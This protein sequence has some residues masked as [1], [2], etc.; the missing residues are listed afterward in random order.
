MPRT[1]QARPKRTPAMFR[2]TQVL[3]KTTKK[4]A[5]KPARKK[6]FQARRNPFIENKTRE[7]K[8]FSASLD[9]MR[10]KTATS[11]PL[12]VPTAFP[13]PTDFRYMPVDDAQTIIL[14]S[15]FYSMNR[16]LTENE[17]IGSAIYGKYL[18][19]KIQLLAPE[20]ANM[21]DYPSN[22]YVIHGWVTAP[23][24]ATGLTVP[25]V[26][27]T[28][29]VDVFTH[30]YNYIKEY[31]SVRKDTLEFPEKR[32]QHIQFLGSRKVL[33]DKNANI[34]VQGV[35][36]VA[37][38]R[39]ALAPINISCKWDINRKIHYSQGTSVAANGNPSNYPQAVF[40]YPNNSWLPF[41]VLFNPQFASTPGYDATAPDP[42]SGVSNNDLWR[43][44]HNSKMWYSDS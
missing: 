31:Y 8:E 34:P 21:I 36:D 20:G 23:L 11:G 4:G 5:Y 27:G 18:K 38:S 28:T 26:T 30:V 29:Y 2:K 16:G 24:Q 41:V 6:A 40:N 39:G 12:A 13:D 17:M 25:S 14:P 9:P 10:D 42:T 35:S 15:P 43:I 3:H 44:A 37:T 1:K 19:T 22:L 7:A 32:V 33:T